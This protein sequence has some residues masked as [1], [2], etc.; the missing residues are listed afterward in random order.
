MRKG[1][2]KLIVYPK[3]NKSQLFNLK[4]DPDETRD[5]SESHPDRVKELTKLIRRNQVHYGD[6][7][8]LTSDEPAKAEVD[9]SFFKIPP[10]KK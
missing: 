5:L 4:D 10:K 6:T 3:I 1:D 9:L 2:W 8:P 7:L